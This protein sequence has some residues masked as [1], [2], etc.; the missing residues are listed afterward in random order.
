MG[1]MNR[2]EDF[3]LIKECQGGAWDDLVRSLNENYLQQRKRTMAT[4]AMNKDKV[5]EIF[6]G[7]FLKM[8]NKD[9]RDEAWT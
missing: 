7:V 4:V 3:D 5:S 1:K 8:D 6:K 9:N 2:F